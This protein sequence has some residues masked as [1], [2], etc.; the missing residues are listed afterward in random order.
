MDFQKREAGRAEG[1]C[2]I[3]ARAGRARPAML[4]LVAVV[5]LDGCLFST[6][7]PEPP[8]GVDNS[9]QNPTEPDTVLRNIRVAFN[10]NNAFNYS[11]S[12]A[13]S[14]RF[15]PDPADAA[16]VGEEFF[17]KWGK[18][19]DT[20]A[21]TNFLALPDSIRF[22]WTVIPN[23]IPDPDAPDD[24]YYQNIQYSV[25][26]DSAG[27]DTLFSGKAD[28]FLRRYVTEWRVRDWVDKRDGS[29]NL[30]L[31]M[32]RWKLGRIWS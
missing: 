12:L 8:V 14:F 32:V 13:D 19:E 5:A 3:A 30:T 23:E 15:E 21:F 20:N 24:R 17:S 9:F 1:G 6:R 28:L 22:A 26:V 7:E 4:L 2:R 29:V 31:G 16:L 18:A 11:R 27:R 25:R 10:L